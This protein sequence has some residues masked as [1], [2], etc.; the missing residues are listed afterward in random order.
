MSNFPTILKDRGVKVGHPLPWNRDK[1]VGVGVDF[2]WTEMPSRNGSYRYHKGVDMYAPVGEAILAVED[3]IVVS[4]PYEE[5]GAY[6]F[7][8]IIEHL[9]DGFTWWS[10]YGHCDEIYLVEA[11]K[12]VRGQEI[13]SVGKTGNASGSHLHLEFRVGE[14][15][16]D[17]SPKRQKVEDPMELVEGIFYWNDARC[18]RR[19]PD[20]DPS[21]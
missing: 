7:M 1:G 15:A 11:D 17:T 18:I 14:N 6:G 10:V 5:Q 2:G 16:H 20:K 21:G 12:V 9:S 8:V 3:G 4:A 13:A 19:E